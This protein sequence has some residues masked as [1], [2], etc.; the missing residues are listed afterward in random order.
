MPCHNS[1][2]S[3]PDIEIIECDEMPP[4]RIMAFSIP[5]N[6][7]RYIGETLPQAIE[8]IVR[9]RRVTVINIGKNNE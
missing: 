1:I 2:S 7:R 5:N 6:W 4:G 9:E 3:Y 8:R